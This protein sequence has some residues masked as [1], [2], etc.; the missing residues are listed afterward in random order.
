MLPR[1]QVLDLATWEEII[2]QLEVSE[3]AIQAYPKTLARERQYEFYHGA[4][5]EFK[6]FKNVFRNSVMHTRDEY[7]RDQA[8]SAFV[9]V[10]DF[11]RILAAEIA[12]G[13]TTPMI[14]VENS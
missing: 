6:R 1:N 4:M 11:M 13:K 5:M 8:H 2:R 14:W 3:Q 9:H 7:D 12:E 10:R